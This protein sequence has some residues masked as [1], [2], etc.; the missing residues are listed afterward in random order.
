[1]FMS[2]TM[3]TLVESLAMIG[4]ISGSFVWYAQ[5]A[6]RREDSEAM[7][8]DSSTQIVFVSKTVATTGHIQ[9]PDAHLGRCGTE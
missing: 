2:E 4:A 8:T 5:V 6:G 1:M 9:D 7:S 3:K